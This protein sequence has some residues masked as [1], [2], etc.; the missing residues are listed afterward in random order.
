GDVGVLYDR[1]CFAQYHR[2]W[3]RRRVLSFDLWHHTHFSRRTTPEFSGLFPRSGGLREE[4]TQVELQSVR[5]LASCSH[6]QT[7]DCLTVRVPC[8]EGQ[9][10]RVHPVRLQHGFVTGHFRVLCAQL[11]RLHHHGTLFPVT[12]VAF[13]ILRRHRHPVGVIGVRGGCVTVR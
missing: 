6:P 10:C 4:S 13:H 5:L 3:H 9:S 11:W 8:E 2:H 1:Y 12:A 7:T